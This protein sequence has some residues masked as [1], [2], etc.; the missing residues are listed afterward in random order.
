MLPGDLVQVGKPNRTSLDRTAVDDTTP[1]I[2]HGLF[3]L[4]FLNAI[5]TSRSSSCWV[6]QCGPTFVG[7]YGPLAVLG[8]AMRKNVR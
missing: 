8:Y 2:E 1:V 6:Y 4:D 7:I 3:V 5:R